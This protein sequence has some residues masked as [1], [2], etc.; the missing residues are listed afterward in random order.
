MLGL[1]VV[2]LLRA[3]SK[4]I[5]KTVVSPVLR[6]LKIPHSNH[7]A[8]DAKV[9]GYNVMTPIRLLNYAVVGWSVVEPCFDLFEWLQI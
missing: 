9:V 8:K 6:L 1:L 5:L 3:I 2:L 4:E 7:E